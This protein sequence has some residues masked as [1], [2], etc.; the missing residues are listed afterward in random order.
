MSYA[1]QRKRFEIYPIFAHWVLV[2][3][4]MIR[5]LW[6]W[7]LLAANN[8]TMA[9]SGHDYESVDAARKA[10]KR[11][12]RMMSLAGVI[13]INAKGKVDYAC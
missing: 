7:R 5:Q 3:N 13:I 12:R 4:P 9:E 2:E 1:R 6:R 11:T 10:V 8:R